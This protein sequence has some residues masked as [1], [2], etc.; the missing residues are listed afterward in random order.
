MITAVATT[1]SLDF[2]PHGSRRDIKVGEHDIQYQTES[3]DMDVR[4][5]EW[6]V[7]DKPELY[8]A[9]AD[10]PELEEV[11]KATINA[12]VTSNGWLQV[13]RRK[14][15]VTGPYVPLAWVRER[16]HELY[17][18]TL[19][20]PAFATDRP[21]AYQVSGLARPCLRV[22]DLAANEDY[23]LEDF[24]AGPVAKYKCVW[25]YGGDAPLPVKVKASYMLPS[26]RFVSVDSVRK[27]FPLLML[28]GDVDPTPEARLYTQG[29]SLVR[30]W[31]PS[32]MIEEHV[33]EV[34]VEAL[35]E[36]G[37]RRSP[38]AAIFAKVI[39][40][41]RIE[42]C[43]KDNPLGFWFFEPSLLAS[44]DA[45]LRSLVHE[46][47]SPG[48]AQPA[49][50]TYPIRD[51]AGRYVPIPCL[52]RLCVADDSLRN[53]FPD[54]DLSDMAAIKQVEGLK[55]NHVSAR[56]EDGELV[57]IGCGN[58]LGS[59]M[60]GEAR[61]LR[62]KLLRQL[63]PHLGP[64]HPELPMERSAPPT[65]EREGD[66]EYACS[67]KC[68]VKMGLAKMLGDKR[69]GPVLD[70]L[71]QTVSLMSRYGSLLVQLD[72]LE[73]LKEG[74]GLL[75]R[76]FKV[77][78]TYVCNAMCFARRSRRPNETKN[79]ELMAAATRHDAILS[80]LR[81][82]YVPGILNSIV[83]EST[84][85]VTSTMNAVD[86]VG[87][88]RIDGVF[89]ACQRLLGV[90]DKAAVARY[91]NYVA[92]GTRM[93]TEPHRRIRGFLD[94]YRALYEEKG[95]SGAGKF[96]VNALEGAELD[97]RFSRIMEL[98]YQI[99]A[100]LTDLET[101]AV[102]TG[103]WKAAGGTKALLTPV[104][105][106]ADVLY[107][108]E[109]TD[110]EDA[111]SDNGEEAEESTAVRFWKRGS[112]A[113]LPVNDLRR[114]TIRIDRN[115]WVGHVYGQLYDMGVEGLEE[116]A[117]ASLFSRAD[118][119]RWRGDIRKI[120]S[121]DK[122]WRLAKSFTTDGVV[123]NMT[124]YNPLLKATPEDKKL[125]KGLVDPEAAYATIDEDSIK[126]GLDAG[127]VNI[128]QVT[129]E[130]DG[131]VCSM[132]YTAK[133]HYEAGH[134]NRVARAREARVKQ[135]AKEAVEAI[136][137]T[138]KRTG[139]L[140]EF[141]TYVQTYNDHHVALWKVFGGRT[142][143]WERF[144]MYQHKMA[145]FD[146]FW[147]RVRLKIA[148][149][150][151][152]KA[153]D[154]SQRPKVTVGWGNAKFKGS[155]KG[156]KP[157]PTSAMSRRVRSTMGQFFDVRMVDEFRTTVTCCCCRERLIKGKRWREMRG[158][159]GWYEDRDV[160]WCNTPSCLESHP[161]S[162]SEELLE[163]ARKVDGARAIDRDA[164]SALAHARLVGIRN[165]Q[166]HVAYRRPEAVTT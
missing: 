30:T 122:G 5:K 136:S 152:W 36:R 161:C 60:I 116:E 72:L 148:P 74:D 55:G 76:P 119:A 86:S 96:Q 66:K 73:R 68:T 89:V 90:N 125:A 141:K 25:D 67:K 95:L 162:A 17:G 58:K 100:D 107:D 32:L 150:K 69:A 62:H 16:N 153:E 64:G 9:V 87:E 135:F 27:A 40:G 6:T 77:S 48:A 113:L 82:D 101:E 146:G 44:H 120:R 108:E 163:G 3:E 31:V 61:I 56:M 138:R 78:S 157:V 104:G 91:R 114:R 10:L 26:E 79:P 121:S 46:L 124:Y 1:R 99:N 165:A 81:V 24:L 70:D 110:E 158:K 143:R 145:S 51:L 85:Y 41:H 123:L 160:K 84:Q 154:P 63:A 4:P 18:L 83:A 97:A 15:G 156:C 71:V 28:E 33:D 106:E 139:S 29:G 98:F 127:V 65:R 75:V 155:M 39:A 49:L 45:T 103:R 128:M 23:D 149:D 109:D 137:G 132:A 47:I 34:D 14:E 22:G 130:H 164:N 129:W 57:K 144:E 11:C 147:R 159:L 38:V 21:V 42:G 134:I 37:K 111:V 93:S 8:V 140:E 35:A 112:F 19:R 59:M 20:H 2:A 52:R 151:E 80:N 12:V 94:K 50:P 117:F 7:I 105:F 126:I 102:A 118:G 142:S 131:K 166:R 133:E 92:N 88:K 53:L 115:V 54:D 43:R 13:K